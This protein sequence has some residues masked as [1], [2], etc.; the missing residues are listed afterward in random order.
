M[1]DKP[2]D[3][4]TQNMK[5]A[6]VTKETHSVNDNAGEADTAVETV[7][8]SGD[9]GESGRGETILREVGD[10]RRTKDVEKD[11]GK[12]KEAKGKA[13]GKKV[14]E[15]VYPVEAIRQKRV[16]EGKVQYLIKWA[17]WK[18]S[19]NTWEPLENLRSISAYIAAFE[20]SLKKAGEKRKGED[21]GSNSQSKKKQQRLT[22]GTSQV[23]LNGE[24]KEYDPTLNELRGQVVNSNGAGSS[25]EGGGEGIGSEGGDNAR[26]NGVLMG[27][28]KE[29]KGG[30]SGVMRRKS[31]IVKRYIRDE[32]TTSN[33]NL[34]T[35]TD[36]QNGTPELDIVRIIKA[37]A[38]STSIT[39]DGHGSLVTFLA[40]RSD[41]EE[42]TVDNKF[43]RAHDPHLLLDFYEQRITYKPESEEKC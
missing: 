28:R 7:G 36:D 38:V 9:G 18:E 21:E 37:V 42:V 11:G 3:S 40:L 13:K 27:K 8:G 16:H 39:D 43:L 20:K 41:G 4:N 10:D 29:K 6:G 23:A 33:K 19:D 35:G 32:T 12:K 17:G 30:V 26:T 5:E 31:F 15:K 22:K 24:E 1:T 34:T 2:L 14:K 25:Q